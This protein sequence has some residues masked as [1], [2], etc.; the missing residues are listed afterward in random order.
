MSIKA[1]ETRY[2]GYRFRSRLEAKWAVFF[3]ALGVQWEYEP[4][5]FETPWGPYLPDFCLQ[6][7]YGPL[8]VEVKGI[9]PTDVE[10]KKLGFVVKGTCSGCGDSPM[11]GLV[12]QDLGSGAGLWE[13]SSDGEI[14]DWYP[15]ESTAEPAH[16][17]VLIELGLEYNGISNATRV[18]GS[19]YLSGV[20][21]A[22]NRARS[23]R[24][25]HGETPA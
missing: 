12:A 4:Q 15:M 1:I 7:V 20:P 13:V 9:K 2:K 22:V 19:T 18:D 3:D 6:G 11:N 16:G 14:V 23:A 21:D 17:P 8:W 24:F 5:G 10:V 25:E